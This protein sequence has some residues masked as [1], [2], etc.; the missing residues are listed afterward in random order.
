[1]IFCENKVD[2]NDIHEYLIF[3]GVELVAIHGGKD[4]EERE[5]S[6][7]S[8][9]AGKKVVLVATDVAS[10]G[11]DFPDIQHVI[12]YDMP[13]EME[14]YVHRIR[15]TGRYGRTGIVTTFVNKNQ[16]ETTLFDLKHLLQ[17]EKQR[18]PPVL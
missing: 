11:L 5:Y 9:K 17:E 6:I 16:I 18:I 4:L 3:Q 15:C 12:N 2:V 8:F 14:N 7:S 13:T 1:M 10:K